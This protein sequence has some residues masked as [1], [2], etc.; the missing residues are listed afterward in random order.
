M[1]RLLG[2]L[3]QASS[4]YSQGE[5][6]CTQALTY[7]LDHKEASEVFLSQL[8][9]RLGT[10]L[11]HQVQWTSEPTQSDG[12][13][14]DIQGDSRATGQ[15]IKIEAKLEAPFGDGQLK[16]YLDDLTMRAACGVLVIIVP[17]YRRLVVER[18]VR[19]TALQFEGS[20]PWKLKRSP[21]I[22]IEDISWEEVLAW[23]SQVDH[24]ALQNDI[25]QFHALYQS[26]V[27]G[28]FQPFDST[29]AISR[30]REQEAT[31]RRLVDQLT[32]E[33]T[34]NHQ[35]LLPIG[36]ESVLLHRRYVLQRIGHS[37]T[38]YAIGLREPIT[39]ETTPF[40]FRVHKDTGGFSDVA[41]RLTST[42]EDFAVYSEAHH[43]WIPLQIP[44]A[45][46]ALDV[47]KDMRRQVAAIEQVAYDGH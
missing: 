37:K 38:F 36:D 40:W 5:Y 1:R 13:R 30:W 10:R 41:H 28:E 16:S 18:A 34:P 47:L 42:G 7:L 26:L 11:N 19:N 45:V 24:R 29:G 12:A 35:K 14:P 2:H 43:L 44:L 32:R 27:H 15:I 25:E 21:H 20:G 22:L 17:N 3:A 31:L 8:S 46:D 4:L 39:P 33:L 6:L 23:L 9:I